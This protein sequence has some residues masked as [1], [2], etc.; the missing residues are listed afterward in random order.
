MNEQPLSL[1]A[2][3][4]EIWRRRVL[5]AVVAV[6][7]GLGGVAF[8]FLKPQDSTAV[9]LVLLP[10]SAASS[11]GAPANDTH[12]DAVI[13]RSTPVLASAG[14]KVS[15]PLGVM[16]LRSLVTVTALSDQ[17]LQFQARAPLGS[18]AE[19]LA[20]AVAASY[21]KYAGQL[22]T[23]SAGSGLAALQKKSSQLTK[24][25]NDLQTQIN[26][27]IARIASEGAGSSAGQQDA[28]LLN[29][30]Q[31]EQK[32][33]SL[34]LEGVTGQ[35]STAQLASGTAASTTQILQYA[36]ALPVDKYSLPITAGIVGFVVGLLG[37]AVFVVVRLPRGRRLR[38]R[39]EIARAAG[40]PVI[41][42]LE[43]PGCTTPS[44]WR[45]LLESRPRAT[46]EWALRHALHTVLNG[47]APRRAVRVIS[48]ADD[49]PALTTGPRLAL[50][51]ATSGTPTGLIPE[52]DSMPES[53][54]LVPLRAVFTGAEPVGRGLPFSIGLNDTGNDPPQLLVSIVVFDG[55]PATLAACDTMN[56]LS[57]S[58]NSVTADD[59][60][61]LALAVADGGSALDGVVVVNPDPNDNTSGHFAEDARRPLTSV[62]HPDGGDNELVRVGARTS[63]TNASPERLSSQER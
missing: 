56:L 9:A 4:Q 2:S 58:P 62:Q 12:T 31:N 32:Q 46:A 5:V 57:I 40:A 45:E 15:P 18:Y 53:R 54:S 10:P 7:C 41:A 13:A 36:A 1:H 21:V 52:D 30:L 23:T 24:S 37:S 19:Q 61:Q 28:N 25:I 43:A 39:D 26:T 63:I 51:A 49:L 59:L 22:A 14:A 33:V 6:I 38:L 29:S 20:N 35:I 3:L 47:G 44:A 34:E 48:F 42:S 17:I 16:K 8:G 55:T 50:H 11:S 60:A 27:V